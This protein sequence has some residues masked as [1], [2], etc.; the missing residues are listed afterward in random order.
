MTLSLRARQKVQTRSEIL[1]A[2]W[3]LSVRD[4]MAATKLS[5]IAALAGVSQQTLYN[6]FSSKD[7]LSLALMD[8][9]EMLSE[10]QSWMADV[11]AELGP[12]DAL[13]DLARRLDW[14]DTAGERRAL[15]MHRIML[16]DPQ[17]H[18]AYRER[19]DEARTYMVDTLAERARRD[20]VSPLRLELIVGCFYVTFDV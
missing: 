11:P 8:G 10:L 3:T 9:W 20:R 17:L 19:Q 4:G 7:E 14:P 18:A 12:A 13:V 16:R 2:A 5:E 15:D 1:Q 6:H